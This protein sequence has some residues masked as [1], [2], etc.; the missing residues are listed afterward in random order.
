[1]NAVVEATDLAKPGVIYILKN[2]NAGVNI[3]KMNLLHPFYMVYIADDGTVICDHL[4]PKKLL[5]VMRHVC[6]NQ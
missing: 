2:R 1:M 3:D 6:K 4:Q 5:D